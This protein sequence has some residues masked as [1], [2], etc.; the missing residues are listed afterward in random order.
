MPLRSTYL[1]CLSAAVLLQSEY[2]QR[3]AAIY[4]KH[5]CNPLK[6]LA[7]V[8]VQ[9]PVFVGFFSALRSFADVKVG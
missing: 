3:V 9:L 1:H 6:S 2:Q 4:R 5:D 8:L 7:S